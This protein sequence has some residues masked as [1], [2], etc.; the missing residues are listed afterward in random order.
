MPAP[1]PPIKAIIIDDEPG[2]IVVLQDM[3]REFCPNVTVIA[4][5]DSV[6]KGREVLATH[7]PEL[8]FLDI[9]LPDGYGFEVLPTEG[10][11]DFD[12]VFTSAYSE[13]AI[14]A[15]DVAALHYLLKPIDVDALTEAV[16]RHREK[17]NSE[18]L[19]AQ[20]RILREG[21]ETPARK[22]SL[23][24][25]EGFFFAEIDQIV[26]LEAEG[27]YTDVVLLDGS[28]VT[29]SRGLNKFDDLLTNNYRFCRVHH[30]HLVN[31][32]RIRNYVK[33]RGGYVLMDD[34]SKV[35]V[36]VRRKEDFLKRM[37]T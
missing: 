29:V 21:L 7:A 12:V 20:Y 17:P 37:G 33:G 1:F 26:R 14:Q 36:S 16:K 24:T 4:T 23:P 6:K 32:D 15:F 3:L 35:D 28:R 19:T 25:F 18:A 31:L 2:S 34:G 13:F 9:A 22:I 10:P 27:S 8:L 5:A 30:K 11:P